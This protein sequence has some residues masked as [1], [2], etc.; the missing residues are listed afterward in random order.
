MINSGSALQQVLSGNLKTPPSATATNK[1]P[2]RLISSRPRGQSMSQAQIH[3]QKSFVKS[4]GMNSRRKMKYQYLTQ[5][6]VEPQ[7]AEQD[8]N[9]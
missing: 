1:K 9:S 2:K 3:I 4:Q 5:Q 8:L 6:V 7:A